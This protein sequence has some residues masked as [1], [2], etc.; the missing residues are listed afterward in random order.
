MYFA[1]GGAAFSLSA[2]AVLDNADGTYTFTGTSS[3]TLV[4]SAFGV[5]WTEGTFDAPPSAYGGGSAQFV[6]GVASSQTITITAAT[7]GWAA[8]GWFAYRLYYSQDPLDLSPSGRAYFAPT[9]AYFLPNDQPTG[10]PTDGQVLTAAWSSRVFGPINMAPLYNVQSGATG[11]PYSNVSPVGTSA[12]YTL[13]ASEVGL[14]VIYQQRALA[15]Q[16]FVDSAQTA[17]IAA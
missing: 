2:I 12:T 13:T 11:G 1:G 9:A 7:E 5:D 6:A 4:G 17:Q 8:G 3:S 14:Y 10:T 16:S 15:G